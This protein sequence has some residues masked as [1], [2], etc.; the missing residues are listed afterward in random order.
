MSKYREVTCTNVEL[1][2]SGDSNWD[3]KI[4]KYLFKW[5]SFRMVGNT[6]LRESIRS[7][8][9]MTRTHK[10]EEFNNVELEEIIKEGRMIQGSLVLKGRM[11]LPP[12]FSKSI[13]YIIYMGRVR[14][15]SKSQSSH[16]AY[17]WTR[18][19]NFFIIF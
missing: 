15:F 18:A 3:Q 19:R 5:P 6:C 2:N 7:S 9:I 14:N 16:I 17:V 13:V 10:S 12:K 11:G 4:C 1:F 8:H